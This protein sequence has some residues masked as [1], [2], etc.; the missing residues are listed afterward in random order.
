MVTQIH[1]RA[2][3]RLG[4]D[5]RAT[6]RHKQDITT[7]R[8]LMNFTIT[9]AT[10]RAT[11]SMERKVWTGCGRP[12]CSGRSL[13]H[14]PH[15]TLPHTRQDVQGQEEQESE[16][17]RADRQGREQAALNEDLLKNHEEVEVALP[18]GVTEEEQVMLTHT[19]AV[20]VLPAQG[21]SEQDCENKCHS[22]FHD[23]VGQPGIEHHHHHDYHHILHHHHSQ[24]HHPHSHSHSH[25]LGRLQGA[26]SHHW[27]GWW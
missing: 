9:M 11:W 13:L 18:A 20:Q 17:G 22:H 5:R 8:A 7:R 15:R 10:M 2:D 24:N 25:G 23:T 27:P 16:K 21:Y 14:V 4:P 6:S 1:Q 26:A 12:H 19:P 3:L